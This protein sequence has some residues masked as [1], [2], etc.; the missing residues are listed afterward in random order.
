M[1]FEGNRAPEHRAAGTRR[2]IPRAGARPANPGRTWNSALGASGDT[3]LQPQVLR[4][5]WH[6]K[7]GSRRIFYFS[8]S[9]EKTLRDQKQDTEWDAV[10]H[11]KRAEASAALAPPRALAQGSASRFPDGKK[12]SQVRGRLQP[13][14]SAAS[15]P[16]PG[17]QT[18]NHSRNFYQQ[19]F[20]E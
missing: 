11:A 19:T 20:T 12:L 17:P 1:C 7:P 15:L 8:A 2:S 10:E 5:R 6:A 13:H 18:G 16:C 3:R 9:A 4:G 14:P